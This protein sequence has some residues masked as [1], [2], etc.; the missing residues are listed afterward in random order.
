MPLIR[1]GA[2]N[3]CEKVSNIT[4][5]LLETKFNQRYEDFTYKSPSLYDFDEFKSDDHVE[6]VANLDDYVSGFS[7]IENK[8]TL[9]AQNNN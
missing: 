5:C 7:S 6:I 8:T 4:P 1:N 9:R 3:L 2:L